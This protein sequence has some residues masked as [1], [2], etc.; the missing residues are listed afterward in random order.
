MGLFGYA[1]L[2]LYIQ[3]LLEGDADVVNRKTVK[4]LLQHAIMRD[5][6]DAF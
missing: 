6:V 1:S 3:E 5:A 4:P 2:K